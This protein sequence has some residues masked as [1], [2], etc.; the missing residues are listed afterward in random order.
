MT[1]EQYEE[2]CRY[3][4]SAKAGLPID[5]IRSIRIPNPKRPGLPEYQH[6]VDLYWE[7]ENELSV[8]LN[9]A[10]AKWRASEKVDQPEVLLLQQV[11]QKVGAHKAVM[12][13]SNGFTAG[14][15][16]AAQDDGISLHILTPR[17]QVPGFPVKD[18]NQMQQVLQELADSSSDPIYSH[19]VEYRALDAPPCNPAPNGGRPAGRPVTYETRVATGHA[20]RAGGGSSQGGGHPGGSNRGDGGFF[21]RGGGSGN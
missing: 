7:I 8:Y 10:N 9:I 19:T 13:T 17:F 14:A 16:A 15:K 20:T 3:F 11:R 1:S 2:L 18:R 12:I 4:L 5:R 6:Q 21:T